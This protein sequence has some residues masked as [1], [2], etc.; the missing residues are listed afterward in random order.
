MRGKTIKKTILNVLLASFITTNLIT[1]ITSATV[2]DENI[3]YDFNTSINSTIDELDYSSM[4]SSAQLP[5]LVKELRLYIESNPN[6]GEEEINNYFD[7]FL[8]SLNFH[9]NFQ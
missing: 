7:F 5:T 1:T 8:K 2:L 6:L 3:E 4:I 9:H